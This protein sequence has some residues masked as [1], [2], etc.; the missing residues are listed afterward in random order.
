MLAYR[1]IDKLI[2]TLVLLAI[3]ALGLFSTFAAGQEPGISLE[4]ETL[5][6]SSQFLSIDITI[7]EDDW[8][9]LLDHAIAEEYYRC[10]VSINGTT[11]R[12]VGIRAKG[13]TSLSMVAA[14]DSDRYSFKLQF[15]EYVSGQTFMG[16]DKLVLNNNYADATMLR[17]AIVYDMF[18]FLDADASLWNYASVYVNGE[19]IG[20]YLAL[21]AVEES[22]ALR[23]YGTNYGNFYKPDSMEMG[24]DFGGFGRSGNAAALEYL[25]DD[26]SSYSVIWESSVF[27]SSDSDHQRVVT[28]LKNIDAE[29][30][31][32]QYMDVDNLLRYLAVHSF[33]VNLDSLSGSMAHNY[34]LYEKNGQ[35]NLIPWDYNLAF[36]GFQSSNASDIVNFPIDTPF[37][38]EERQFFMALLHNEEY[39]RQ[40]HAYLQQLTSEYVNGGRLDALYQ[41]LRSQLDPLVE[42]DPTAFY[43]YDQY[44]TA[45]EMLIQTI[46]LRAESVQGQLEGRI[47]STTEGQRNDASSLVD[48]SAI[49]LSAMGTMGGGE[50]G[51]GFGGGNFDFPGDFSNIPNAEGGNTPPSLPDNMDFSPDMTPPGGMDFSADAAPPGGMD[52]PTDATP[53]DGMD[54]PT[55]A[56]PPDGMDFPTDATP[57]GGE[58]DSNDASESDHSKPQESAADQTTPSGGDRRPGNRPDDNWD[59]S[60]F[61]SSGS[62]LSQTLLLYGACLLL[63][64]LALLWIR[65]YRRR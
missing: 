51:G 25:G 26:L 48:A 40:Y 53:P 57:P 58:A 16:L 10:D 1:H 59:F 12:S 2:I 33:A 64:L 17:E 50:A 9:D 28:A 63:I 20:V 14:S 46:Q 8:Q 49:Q 32:A 24:G 5:F 43:S 42:T 13:N 38:S 60:N 11:C 61:D 18:A 30:D 41:S 65:R 27:S 56:T 21:E 39:L 44:N 6:D 55:D 52:F 54:F 31:L 19:Y 15:D 23:N 47:P 34:Y 4:Y 37:S 3:L 62:S 45:A 7:E 29:T 22:F 35:L 36:G